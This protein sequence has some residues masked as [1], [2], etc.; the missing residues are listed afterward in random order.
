[1]NQFALAFYVRKD[2]AADS[3][4]RVAV[5]FLH[6]LPF[7]SF[8]ARELHCALCTVLLFCCEILIGDR[9]DNSNVSYF[10]ALTVVRQV[11]TSCLFANRRP[12]P[13]YFIGYLI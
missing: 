4:I 2:A 1:M 11:K 6:M 9:L 8:P 5:D 12:E 3:D 13:I 10:R 7:S